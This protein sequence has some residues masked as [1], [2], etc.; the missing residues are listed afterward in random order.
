MNSA[1]LKQLTTAEWRHSRRMTSSEVL[2]KIKLMGFFGTL[3]LQIHFLRIKIN[4]FRGD[5]SDVS[6]KTATLMTSTSWGQGPTK[7][8]MTVAVSCTAVTRTV[9]TFLESAL[10]KLSYCLYKTSASHELSG[11]FARKEGY[12]RFPSACIG[13]NLSGRYPER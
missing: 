3:M 9:G 5:L 8:I 1:V 7:V 4:N 13:Y 12:K 6:A 2:F 11:A 10:K